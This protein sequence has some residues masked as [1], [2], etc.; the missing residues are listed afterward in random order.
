MLAVSQPIST[1][2]VVRK[3]PVDLPKELRVS[4]PKPAVLPPVA[5]MPS[6]LAKTPIRTAPARNRSSPRHRARR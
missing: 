5:T 2:R 3:I 4:P 1:V 6:K